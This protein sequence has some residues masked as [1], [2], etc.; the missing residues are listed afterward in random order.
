MIR[1]ICTLFLLCLIA[2]SA[3]AQTEE[4]Y[5]L[6][7]IDNA[8]QKLQGVINTKNFGRTFDANLVRLK[9]N[10]LTNEG[11]QCTYHKH[12]K[13]NGPAFSQSMEEEN[14]RYTFD[15][16]A[17]KK[18]FSFV[19]DSKNM[20]MKVRLRTKGGIKAIKREN[21]FRPDETMMVDRVEIIFPYE[22][23]EKTKLIQKER[24]KFIL[25]SAHEL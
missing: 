6:N 15:L 1:T 11:T 22:M 3:R 25:K 4:E 17:I 2:L 10:E 7:D 12:V 21:L 23:N 9:V 18:E 16:Q 13:R 14:Y 19:G 24:L 5:I 8:M 20:L